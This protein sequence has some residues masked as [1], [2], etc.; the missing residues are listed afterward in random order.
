MNKNLNIIDPRTEGVKLDLRIIEVTKGVA[1]Q[2][3][4]VHLSPAWIEKHG[5]ELPRE[6]QPNAQVSMNQIYNFL[7]SKELVFNKFEDDEKL[8]SITK[9]KDG[10]FGDKEYT[11]KML[12]KAR[13]TEMA[14]LEEREAIKVKEEI[15]RREVEMTPKE[16]IKV[17]EKL[18][19]ELNE[20]DFKN[21]PDLVKG[22]EIG[23]E[24]EIDEFGFFVLIEDKLV[25]KPIEK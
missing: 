20:E 11:Q 15:A 5:K 23:N 16:E 13:A 14:D 3:A 9:N 18:Y 24:V 25:L 19:H 21:S 1:Y 10:V 6:F 7:H 17:P 12:K 4:S 8:Y 22:F 2:I